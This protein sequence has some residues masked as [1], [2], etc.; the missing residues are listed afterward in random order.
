M[1]F[2]NNFF[3]DGYLDNHVR[4]GSLV[5]ETALNLNDPELEISLAI[6]LFDECPSI[7]NGSNHLLQIIKDALPCHHV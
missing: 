2:N 5:A 4:N 1:Q 7:Y 3:F 6:L